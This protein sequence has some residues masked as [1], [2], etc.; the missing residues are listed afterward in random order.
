MREQL[1]AAAPEAEIKTWA[2]LQPPSWLLR[3]MTHELAVHRWD[4]EAAGGDPQP[5][6]AAVA[7]DGIDE[8]LQE[9]VPAADLGRVGGTLHLHATD[10]DG[11]WFIETVDGLAWSRAHEKGD[12]AVRGRTSD[13]LLFLWGRAGLDDVEVL[14]DDCGPDPVAGGDEVLDATGPPARKT[15]GPEGLGG[16][17]PSS[18]QGLH[19]SGVALV[20]EGGDVVEVEVVEAVLPLAA[21]R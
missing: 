16:A 3:R 15:E 13:L 4:A 19:D 9:F 8:L 18:A 20:V 7:E 5:L 14:G 6:D 17:E 10:G 1:A 2:G 12:V 21:P 11:E